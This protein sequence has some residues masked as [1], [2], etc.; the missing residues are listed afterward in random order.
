MFSPRNN[1]PFG[2]QR[3][4]STYQYQTLPY[5]MVSTQAGGLVSKVMALL[6]CSFLIAT[7]GPLSALALV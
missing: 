2:G 1:S 7:V 5:G 6:A 3:N 4:G